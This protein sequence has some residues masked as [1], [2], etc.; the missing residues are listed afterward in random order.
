MTGDAVVVYEITAGNQ[1]RG[2]IEYEA[3]FFNVN[4]IHIRSII[5]AKGSEILFLDSRRGVVSVTW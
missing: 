4:R 1:L 2:K 3:K 5:R